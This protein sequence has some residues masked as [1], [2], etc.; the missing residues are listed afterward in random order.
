MEYRAEI[1][2]HAERSRSGV[3]LPETRKKELISKVA[4]PVT[5][6]GE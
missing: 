5:G 4:L 6:A 3:A 2:P 1:C